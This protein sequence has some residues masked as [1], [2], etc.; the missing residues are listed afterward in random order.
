MS[1]QHNGP[2]MLTPRLIIALCTCFLLWSTT[3]CARIDTRT[4]VLA[5]GE[6]DV[7]FEQDM[8]EQFAQGAQAMGKDTSEVVV[9]NQTLPDGII[10]EDG[11][12]KA[13]PQSGQ[14][15]IA[16]FE[17][18]SHNG[19]FRDYTQKWRKAVCYP[20]NVLVALTL[21]A[22]MLV[23]AYYPCWAKGRYPKSFLVEEARRLTRLAG[24]NAAT[25]QFYGEFE[26]EARG[27]TGYILRLDPTEVLPET[28]EVSIP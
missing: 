11:V 15:V 10:V 12:I 27:L 26:D 6:V 4:N 25:I 7:A 20:Q 19:L 21:A 16:K 23:P 28:K 17:I 8:E 2:T 13:D 14:E 22:W 3:G 5:Y 1:S 9:L 24:G 18:R